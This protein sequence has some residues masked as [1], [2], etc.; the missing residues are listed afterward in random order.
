MAG[1]RALWQAMEHNTTLRWLDVRCN[2]IIVNHNGT[3]AAIL[4]VMEGWT[5]VLQRYNE[6]LS[7]LELWQTKERQALACVST[8]AAAQNQ[9]EFW[10]KW[11]RAGR[12]LCKYGSSHDSNDAATTTTSNDTD[13]VPVSRLLANAAAASPTVVWATLQARPDW[14]VLGRK[15]SSRGTAKASSCDE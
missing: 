1:M 11:N 15:E 10:L 9:L 8:L 4:T 13:I 6:T 14:V 5:H 7:N 3:N 12:R 2:K